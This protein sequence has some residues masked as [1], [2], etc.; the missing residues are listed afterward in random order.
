MAELRILK[1]GDEAAL[2]AF[3]LRHAASSMFL[4]SNSRAVGLADHGERLEGTYAAGFDGPEIVAVAAHYWNGNVV[5]QAPDHLTA[6]LDL[7]VGRSGR[8]VKGLV[9]PWVQAETA[10]RRLDLDA[11]SAS[12]FSREIL[13]SLPLD[14]L[15]VPAPLASGNVLCRAARADEVEWLAAC[16]R[17]YQVEAVGRMDSPDLLDEC[18]EAAGW[19]FEKWW[20][21]TENDSPVSCTTFNARLPDMVQVGGVF[22]PPDLRGQGYGRAVVAGSL[23]TARD[24]GVETAILFTAE[25]NEPA[26][27]AYRA[28]GFEEIGDY[29]LLLW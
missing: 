4:R 24:E 9:G 2:E 17:T 25:E 13:M 8:A 27:R 18:R 21:L 26:Q 28:L 23:L 6:V 3:L 7:A 22:T 29:G 14:R 20:V 19:N 16:N 5:L 11:N 10:R 12:L 15:K 1:P